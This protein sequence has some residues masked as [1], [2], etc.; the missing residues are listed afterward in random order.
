MTD[1]KMLT[2]DEVSELINATL[3]FCVSNSIV[4]ASFL[5]CNYSYKVITLKII[6]Y[7]RNKST[8][9]SIIQ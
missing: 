8:K 5:Q 1:L 7:Y 4:L 9:N 6:L 3:I 2:Q